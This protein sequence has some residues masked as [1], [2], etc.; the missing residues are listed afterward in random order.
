[1]KKFNY[2]YLLLTLAFSV[3]ALAIWAAKLHRDKQLNLN[4]KAA[5]AHTRVF[6]NDEL[7]DRLAKV[8]TK[9]SVKADELLLV[10]QIQLNNIVEGKEEKEDPVAY[11]FSKKDKEFFYQMGKV[12]YYNNKKIGVV[13]D[14]DQHRIDVL[15]PVDANANMMPL[16]NINNMPELVRSEG[17]VMTTT[18]EGNLQT[19][20]L[21]NKNHFT[22]KEYA[23]TFDTLSYLPK[24]IFARFTG[25]SNAETH[26]GERL[27]YVRF[28]KAEPQS[29][30]SDYLLNAPIQLEAG[31]WKVQPKYKSYQVF[32]LK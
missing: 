26:N 29:N 19:I 16:A 1:M 20:V 31:Q 25:D 17:F 18:S 14:D 22:C 15:K 28:D 13:V 8:S 7:Y 27:L 21:K 6:T 3:T 4:K 5:P 23:L 32:G 2:K 9:M 10:G 11:I 12:A 30:I 24:R